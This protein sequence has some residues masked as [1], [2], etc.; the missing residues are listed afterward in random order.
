MLQKQRARVRERAREKKRRLPN[1][2]LSWKYKINGITL[3]SS[4]ACEEVKGGEE[5]TERQNAS[6][7]K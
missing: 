7:P 2:I 6:K 5:K 3:L 1:A 4:C